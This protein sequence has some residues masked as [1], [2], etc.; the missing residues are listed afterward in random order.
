[1]TDVVRQKLQAL[2]SQF[3]VAVCND[4]KRCEAL[5]KDLCPQNKREVRLLVIALGDGA[6]KKLSQPSSLMTTEN[7]IAQLVQSLDENWGIASHHAQWAVESWALALGIQFNS[8]AI[9]P[10]PD[11]GKVGMGLPKSAAQTNTPQPKAVQPIVTQNPADHAAAFEQLKQ[12]KAL[13]EQQQL[14]VEAEKNWQKIG[15]QGELL[16]FDAP[17]WAAAID[18]KTQLMWAINPSKTASF[19][20]PNKDMNWEDAMAWA[21]YVNTQGW[22]GFNDWRLPKIE[23]LETLITK[24]KQPKF[25]ICQLVFNDK[26]EISKVWSASNDGKHYVDFSGPNEGFSNNSYKY[27]K[28]YTHWAYVRLV[29]SSY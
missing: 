4:V 17:H 2:I 25:Y 21:E 16:T 10:S 5:L 28:F 20:N 7:L 3:G 11:K 27:H 23:E 6:V 12:Q 22:C 9:A 1:M 19:P 18:K 26:D 13:A 14:Q 15:Q 8:S 24:N 29:R